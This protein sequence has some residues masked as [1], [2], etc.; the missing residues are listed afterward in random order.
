MSFCENCGKEIIEGR[1]Y[2]G[3]CGVSVN[4]SVIE[5][6]DNNAMEE[7]Y[8]Y[9][10]DKSF[11]QLSENE[12]KIKTYHCSTLKRPSGDGYLT[13]TN[14]RVV[15]HGY[16]ASSR[17]V[18]EVPI[19]TVAGISTYYGKGWKLPFIILGVICSFA[20]F[21]TLSLGNG[22]LA[23]ITLGIAALFFFLARN[24]SY[25]LSVFSTGGSSTPINIGNGTLGT[26][27]MG[28]GAALTVVASP[29]SETEKMMDE[30]G[31]IVMDFKTMGD[32]AIDKWMCSKEIKNV[33]VKK[34][35][36]KE[37]ITD[38]EFFN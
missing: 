15:F 6:K 10:H 32:H 9:N 22:F 31:A 1:E 35:I 3:N 37:N 36:V 13:V 17:F 33:N 34:N 2:C 30:L 16:G 20:F 38:G 28:Q 26:M 14:K 21:G 23:I 18:S 12:M 19:E 11:V 7:N 25:N 29:T 24:V 4:G 27:I 8:S 5:G